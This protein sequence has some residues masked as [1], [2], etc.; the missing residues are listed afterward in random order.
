MKLKALIFSLVCMCSFI[1]GINA[2]AK[3]G[4][5]VWQ[6]G[7]DIRW[8]EYDPYDG[9][10]YEY[11]RDNN[12]IVAYSKDDFSRLWESGNLG[13]GFYGGL[14]GLFGLDINTIDKPFIVASKDSIYLASPQNSSINTAVIQK[15]SKKNG[16]LIWERELKKREKDDN[17]TYQYRVLVHSIS[18]TTRGLY[19]SYT[20]STSYESWG[21]SVYG[22]TGIYKVDVETGEKIWGNSLRKGEYPNP[23]QPL[24]VYAY[25]GKNNDFVYSVGRCSGNCD[26]ISSE[27]T[28]A[29]S[30]IDQNTG[31]IKWNTRVYASDGSA[32]SIEC[33]NSIQFDEE[34]N[35]YI[36]GN[37]FM[38]VPNSDK[39]IKVNARS[40]RVDAISRAFS[41]SYAAMEL[42]YYNGDLYG[43]SGSPFGSLTL[44][45]LNSDDLSENW[46]KVY[47]TDSSFYPMHVSGKLSGDYYY[48][49]YKQRWYE[50]RIHG[51]MYVD[52]SGIYTLDARHLDNN[53]PFT[54]LISNPKKIC[55]RDEDC[56]KNAKYISHTYSL[57]NGSSWLS[58]FPKRLET[59]QDMSISM[60]MKNI[61]NVF[62]YKSIDKT[63]V[64]SGVGKNVYSAEQPLVEQSIMFRS[65]KWNSGTTDAHFSTE[66]PKVFSA[67]EN[68][69]DTFIGSQ[70]K[71]I[72]PWRSL[73]TDIPFDNP[74][75]DPGETVTFT[76]NFTA[77]TISGCYEFES[78]QMSAKRSDSVGGIEWFGDKTPK[79]T[80]AVGVDPATCKIPTDCTP[81]YRCTSIPTSEKCDN[82]NC[83]KTITTKRSICYDR[84][85]CSGGDGVVSKEVCQE[86]NKPCPNDVTEVCSCP[87]TSKGIFREVAP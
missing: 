70:M 6:K 76:Q 48:I 65:E 38:E 37:D 72:G 25:D 68:I 44:F 12:T 83:D 35:I 22:P 67:M 11:N 23:Y 13:D 16:A 36:F 15:R 56:V 26:S 69:S 60:V 14:S 28:P 78:W 7:I 24:S 79:E 17:S 82:T 62:W 87:K 39:I 2:E 8:G 66:Y 59:G 4:D 86:K 43:L 5:V 74:V 55:I 75:V 50:I 46:R 41:F 63:G 77:P 73:I 57:D 20:D 71:S 34:G 80:I 18:A 1:L 32:G 9:T 29:L 45:S 64:F 58:G 53:N 85:K 52:D 54:N 33:Q 49:K 19:L 47:A 84:E 31:K 40:G 3:V 42:F 61:G 51:G 10:F 21:T 30:R 27:R 81:D